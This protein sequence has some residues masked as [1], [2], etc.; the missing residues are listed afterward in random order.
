LTGAYGVSGILENI[1]SG[2]AKKGINLRDPREG[3]G[4]PMWEEWQAAP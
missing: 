3:E 4:C 1:K 2:R